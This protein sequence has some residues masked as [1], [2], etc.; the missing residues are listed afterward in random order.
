MISSKE[1]VIFG[2]FFTL[3]ITEKISLF[4][5]RRQSVGYLP[6]PQ[7]TKMAIS[8]GRKR[9]PSEQ[10]NA[11]TRMIMRATG[12]KIREP[13]TTIKLKSLI[14]KKD[15]PP[16]KKRPAAAKRKLVHITESSYSETVKLKTEE[17]PAKKKAITPTLNKGT[18]LTEK[19]SA[20]NAQSAIFQITDFQTVKEYF[21]KFGY[22]CLEGGDPEEARRSAHNR[23]RNSERGMRD[24]L[25]RLSNRMIELKDAASTDKSVEQLPP[26]LRINP[27]S[28]RRRSTL[29]YEFLLRCFGA[30]GQD[31]ISYD[32]IS[33]LKKKRAVVKLA[34]RKWEE[35]YMRAPKEGEAA[36]KYG[37]DCWG[38]SITNTPNGGFTL[39]AFCFPDE[40]MEAKAGKAAL[41]TNRPCIFCLRAENMDM[42]LNVICTGMGLKEDEVIQ[43]HRNDVNEYPEEYMMMGESELYQGILDPIVCF[44]LSDYEYK[45]VDGH[46]YYIQNIPWPDSSS[47]SKK[48]AAEDGH[49]LA[50]TP[51]PSHTPH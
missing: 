11:I 13:S 50:K 17:R 3:N 26:S 22:C 45:E 27:I 42:I 21:K 5:L 44:N 49:F 29:D 6:P 7:S 15:T 10:G 14:P 33:N 1:T 18:K 31:K 2:L 40:V 9:G 23:L 39:A 46:C 38:R 19:I 12:M 37:V 48:S 41:P 25:L 32:G 24:E 43:T 51:P 47:Q 8:R 4:I 30:H 35:S 16:S 34:Q 36:C 20:L 28:M